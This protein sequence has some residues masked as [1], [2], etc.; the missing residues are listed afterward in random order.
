MKLRS[1][2]T[3]RRQ[4]AGLE[5]PLRKSTNGSRVEK[6]RSSALRGPSGYYQASLYVNA[7]NENTR[8]ADVTRQSLWR[9]LRCGS[10]DGELLLV[11]DELDQGIA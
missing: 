11:F 3:N 1:D 9:I 7:N 2:D 10:V 4:R 8:S 5:A 6:R